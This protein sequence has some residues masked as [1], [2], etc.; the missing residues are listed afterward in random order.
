[1]HRLLAQATIGVCI[2]CC[3]GVALCFPAAL[4]WPERAVSYTYF[5]VFGIACAWALLRP[6]VRGAIELLYVAALAALTVPLSN[7]I[8]TGDHLLRSVPSGHW[9]IAGFDIGAIALA[10]GFVAL[11]RATQRRARS[12]PAESVWAMPRAAT[13]ATA[14]AG[15]KP[16]SGADAR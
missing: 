16:M 12:G 2:G 15:A 13:A 10:A 9:I 1:M 4:L 5:T 6:P 3:I 11:A 8:L 14:T 7:A